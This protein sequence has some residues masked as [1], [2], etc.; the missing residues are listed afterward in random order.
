M[1]VSRISSFISVV[2]F[3][4]LFFLVGVVGAK[5]AT[6][7]TSTATNVTSPYHIDT[8]T[9]DNRN[10]F[11]LE[12]AK[13]EVFLNP[14]QSS[15]NTLY[16]TDRVQGTTTFSISV[17]DIK[18]SSNPNAPV[19][20]LGPGDV[21][22][23]SAQNFISIP[24]KQFTLTFGERATIPVT[25]TIPKNTSPG[26]YYAAVLV[27]NEPTVTAETQNAST[28]GTTRV[29]SRI[30]TLFFI[31]VN[32][33]ANPA[34]ML[35]GFRIN[36]P[37]NQAIYNSGPFTFEILFNNTGNLYLTPYGTITIKNMFGETVATIPV[38]AYYSLPQSLRYRDIAW[39]GQALFGRYTATLTLNRSYGNIVDTQTLTFWVIPWKFLIIAFI[40]LFVI[41]L[42]GILFLRRFEIRKKQP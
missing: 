16:V 13:Q 40:I 24:A 31:R 5:A 10:D 37:S 2:V 22:P 30:G 27:S 25:I 28:A 11:V 41:V 35:Q 26:G 3:S 9:V 32:G 4:T 33:P 21:T 23:D 38:N 20:I 29:I 7:S 17:Q 39:D 1:K 12:P 8:L 34:G 14:G 42:G 15:T 18:G 36:A 6:T 19:V